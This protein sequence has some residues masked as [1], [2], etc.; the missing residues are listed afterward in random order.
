M[1]ERPP[2]TVAY[3]SAGS[4]IE[5]MEHLDA[6]VVM[7]RESVNVLAISTVY[8][9]PAIGRPDDPD[10][11]NCVFQVEA[12]MPPRALK[13]DVLRA[14]EAQLGRE[15]SSDKYGPRRIDL[16]LVLYGEETIDEPDLKIPHP[17]VSRW[18]VRVPLLELSPML[19]V[20]G[21][22]LELQGSEGVESEQEKGEPLP[23]FTELLRRRLEE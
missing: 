13:F 2:G 19:D 7:L 14:I 9:T 16:D 17:D 23:G 5:P 21:L 12:S 20:H 1:P 10:F 3:I 18:F 22:G 6:A 4:S 15:K 8:R 11:L